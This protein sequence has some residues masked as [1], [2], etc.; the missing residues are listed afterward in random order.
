MNKKARGR[1]SL[2]A[3]YAHFNVRTQKGM[4]IE[5]SHIIQKEEM[6]E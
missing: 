4:V 2:R 6:N 5:G 3:Q 1:R